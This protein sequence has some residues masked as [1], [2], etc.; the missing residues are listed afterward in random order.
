MLV[1][2]LY[3]MT[4]VFLCVFFFLV[5]PCR[6]VANPVRLNSNV[7]WSSDVLDSRPEYLYVLGWGFSLGSMILEQLVIL[8]VSMLCCLM[9]LYQS[10]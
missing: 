5:V 1:R 9:L 8:L 6:V 7:M 10:T 4:F 2:F 3:R